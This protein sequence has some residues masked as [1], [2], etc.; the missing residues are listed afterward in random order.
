[1]SFEKAEKEILKKKKKKK[2]GLGFKVWGLSLWGDSVSW[3]FYLYI[4]IIEKCL[5]GLKPKCIPLIFLYPFR[6]N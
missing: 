3:A 5:V 6:L 2:K 1:M 4:I